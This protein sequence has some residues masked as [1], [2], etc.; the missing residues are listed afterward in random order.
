[1]DNAITWTNWAGTAECQPHSFLYPTS[2]EEIQEIIKDAVRNNKKVRVAGKGHS[3]TKLIETNS[4]LIS[5]DKWSGVIEVEGEIVEVRAG[6]NLKYLGG[7]LYNLGLAMENLGDIDV[8]SLAGAFSTGT[9]GTGIEFGTLSTQ[10]VELTL[11]NGKGELITC[12]E[13]QNR[14][15]FK[16]AQISIGAIGVIT[17]MKLRCIPKYKLELINKKADFKEC[18]SKLNQYNQENRNFEFYYFPYTETVQMKIANVT[19]KNPK[20]G[21]IMKYLNDMVLENGIFKLMSEVSRIIPSKSKSISKLVALFVGESKKNTWSHEVYAT[22]RLVRFTEMEYN[23]PREHFEKCILE[24]KQKI[25]EMQYELHFPIECRFVKADDIWL[26][27][28]YQRESAYIAVHM[29]K[30]M[31]FEEYFK[32][33]E[34]I[35]K[36]YDGRPHW[37]KLHKLNSQELKAR[38]PK[39]DAFHS[40]RK[41]MDPQGLFMN[42]YLNSIFG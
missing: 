38:Y 39:W 1:M 12:S 24:I 32:D 16:A 17:R 23:I 29:Y 18:L 33:M 22:T 36:K 10:L 14:E 30:G 28:A 41:Q 11:V 8:Q 13:T 27:P 4:I 20:K 31:P 7:Q 25:E 37:G 9:H 42:D 26:S 15:I 5:L 21:G 19:D 2:E 3:F 35:F 40:V 34:D 6:T